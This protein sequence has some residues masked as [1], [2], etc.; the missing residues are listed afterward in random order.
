MHAKNTLL[1]FH[2]LT[3]GRHEKIPGAA[4][5]V[6]AVATSPVVAQGTCD[7]ACLLKTA[8]DYLAA[9][10]AYD[11]SKAPMAPTA[12]LTEQ[13]KVMKAGEE[14]GDVNVDDV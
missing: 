12:K 5:L 2:V 11:A 1:R 9:L 14:E 13:A 8:D 6:A 3:E 4:L 7:R 10:V